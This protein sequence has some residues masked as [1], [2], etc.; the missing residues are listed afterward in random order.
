MVEYPGYLSHTIVRAVLHGGNLD[1]PFPCQTETDGVGVRSMIDRT[2][3]F[4]VRL[5]ER[6]REREIDGVGVS[7]VKQF[8]GSKRVR[9]NADATLLVFVYQWIGG[10]TN[11]PGF[12]RNSNEF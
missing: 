4:L 2:K 7:R 10:I 9:V 12:V 8:C 3:H 5:R 11:Y 6:E 1:L